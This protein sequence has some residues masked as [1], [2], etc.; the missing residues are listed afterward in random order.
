MDSVIKIKFVCMILFGIYNWLVT[1][2]AS[3]LFAS[4]SLSLSISC[5]SS[6]FLGGR[7]ERPKRRRGLKYREMRERLSGYRNFAKDLTWD[8]ILLMAVGCVG[9]KIPVS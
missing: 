5:T 8:E 7:A 9:E 3:E 6:L 4:L 2:L 1:K